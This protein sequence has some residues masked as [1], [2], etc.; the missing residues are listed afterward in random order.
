M[1]SVSSQRCVCLLSPALLGRGSGIGML[2]TPYNELIIMCE[3]GFS[4]HERYVFCTIQLSVSR[5][6]LYALPRD[7]LCYEK[8]YIYRVFLERYED[9]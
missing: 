1:E 2:D 3:M 8:K 7:S 5:S 4:D 6:L 9:Q